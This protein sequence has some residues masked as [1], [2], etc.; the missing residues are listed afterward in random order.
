MLYSPLE[1]YDFS[2]KDPEF[3]GLAQAH[4]LTRACFVTELPLLPFRTKL[5][6]MRHPFYQSVYQHAL[7]L[8]PTFARELEA[9][10]IR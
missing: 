10:I 3:G 1:R 8:N 7:E 4:Q 2:L 5:K 9:C 6:D